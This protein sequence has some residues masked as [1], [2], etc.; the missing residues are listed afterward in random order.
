MLVICS[1]AAV[2][3]Q[4][5]QLVHA[6]VPNVDIMVCNGGSCCRGQQVAVDQSIHPESNSCQK[7]ESGIVIRAVMRTVC[8]SAG[9]AGLAGVQRTQKEKSGYTF[10]Q[11]F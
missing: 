10:W 7:T 2:H 8:S 11:D 6:M 4:H 9:T 3:Y 1:C 5:C